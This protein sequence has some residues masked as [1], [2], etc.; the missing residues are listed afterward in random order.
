MQGIMRPAQF[1][2]LT[3]QLIVCLALCGALIAPAGASARK[4]GDLDPSFGDGGR[5]VTKFC[6]HPRKWGV[7][8]DRHGRTVVA[9][10]N[11]EHSSFCVARYRRDGSLDPSF[12]TRGEVTT[13]FGGG[14][15]PFAVAIDS[16][17]RIVA[18][19][20]YG[21]SPGKHVPLDRFALARYK[22]D[23]TLDP[24]FGDGG[25]LTTDFPGG[26][27]TKAN[28]VAID[29][30][31]R[32]VAAGV[33]G[34]NFALARYTRNGDLDASF[35]GGAVTTDF[36]VHDTANSVAIDRRGRIIAAG[37][38]GND[39]ALA[40]YEE[41]GTLDDSFSGDGK[42]TT[43]F[44]GDDKATSVAIDRHGRVVAAGTDGEKFALA[45]YTSRGRLDGSF[46]SDGRVKTELAPGAG[47]EGLAIDSR[48]RIV[49]AGG[50]FDL[51]RYKPNGSL[52]RSFG[53][54]GRV[55]TRS[56][57][58]GATVTAAAVDARD[59][60]VVVGD[61][62]FLVLGRFIGYRPR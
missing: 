31:G 7:A 45:R 28:G 58:R 51:A 5:V 14:A 60:I 19:G 4:A 29:S 23:G 57:F 6:T 44:G 18:A 62:S 15:A 25:K 59:R 56:R 36:G 52:D 38:T 1:A 3:F 50:S 20:A 39:F 13:D 26:A 40:R 53:R 43:A 30:L 37:G 22:P 11:G 32:V 35:T 8:I 49:A 54:R 27:F 12:G 17:G 21:P 10:A 55:V 33:A 46:D 48:G 41:N 16:H 34:G 61:H 2:A 42:K 47:A 24:S 9:G